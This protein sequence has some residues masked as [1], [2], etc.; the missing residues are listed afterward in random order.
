MKTKYLYLLFILSFVVGCTD[1]EPVLDAAIDENAVWKDRDFAIGVLNDAYNQLPAY[2]TDELGTFLDCATDN[3]VTNNFSSGII[4]MATG[5]WTA[6]N[7]PINSWTLCYNQIRNLNQFIEKSTE[8]SFSNDTTKNKL[9]HKRIKGEAYFLRA[10]YQFELLSRFS[11]LDENGNLLGFPIVKDA[12]SDVELKTVGRNTFDACVAVIKDDIDTA[13]VYLPDAQYNGSDVVLG[14]T[15]TGRVYRLPA[16]ALKSR[17]LLYA[18]SPAYTTTKSPAEKQT[19]WADAAVAAMAAIQAKGALP[20]VSASGDMYSN[21]N[22]AEIIWRSYQPDSNAPEKDDFMPSLWGNGR[23]N[24]SQQLVDAFPMKDGYPISESVTYNATNPYANRDNRFGL[25]IIHNGATFGS[26]KADI[27]AGGKDAES[28]GQTRT[29]RTGYYLRKFIVPGVIITPGLTATTTKHYYA[30]FRSAELW[31][32]YAEAANEAWGPDADPQSLGKTAKTILA[33]LRKRAGIATADPYLNQQAAAGKD[34][35]RALV[36]NE[37]RIELCFENHRFFDVRRW[38]LPLSELNKDVS[39][40]MITK[41]D[42]NVFNYQ[43]VAKVE[44]RK[45]QD[46]MYYGPIPEQ[47]IYA[48][49]GNI[50]QNAGW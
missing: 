13:L 6:Q 50:V 47:A 40:V 7:N 8:I 11:G 48:S 21:P 5:G 45:F 35:F 26:E 41:D 37:R 28:N 9:I 18:A 1:L 19:L 27:F 30:F 14:A 39:G 4:T 15:Q 2:Y 23:T 38:L 36:Q 29:T 42:N 31:L 33:E 43:P 3:A 20:A 10:W 24:P 16:L 25:S 22:H 49:E 44:I 17:L 46:Y 32:N 12:L 34:V